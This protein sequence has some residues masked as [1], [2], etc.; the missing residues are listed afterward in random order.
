MKRL[1]HWPLDPA[2]RLVRL[3]LGEKGEGFETLESP[4]WAPH[5]DVPRLAHGAVAP[6]LVEI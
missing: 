2:G 6:A 3:A 5:P 1:Y 4:S